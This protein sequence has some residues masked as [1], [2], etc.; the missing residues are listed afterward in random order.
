MLNAK[1]VNKEWEDRWLNYL[2]LD[3]IDW[4]PI[5]TQ[6]HS[7]LNNNYVKSA[8]WESFHLNFWSNFRANERCKLCMEPENDITH[9]INDCKMLSEIIESLNLNH[10]FDNKF[11]ITFGVEN[12][13]I[14]NYIMFHIKS[15]V[16]R[17]RF[18]IFHNFAAGKSQLIKK[19]KNN[20]KQ[21]LKSKFDI[22]KSKNKIDEF[23]NIFLPSQVEGENTHFYFWKINEEHNLEFF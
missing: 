16:F 9:I 4:G 3:E 23:F 21:D 19:C 6:L 14:A 18:K 20:I 15:V 8:I 13:N 11:K 10:I 1:S 17:S 22:A 5:W 2:L 12:E 7:N